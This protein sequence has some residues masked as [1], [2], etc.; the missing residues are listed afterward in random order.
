MSP[1]QFVNSNLI[2]C[3]IKRPLTAFEILILDVQSG[4]KW[5]P[6]VIYQLLLDSECGTSDGLR[7][8]L[9]MNLGINIGRLFL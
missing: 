5:D 4:S 8:C 2:L 7:E 9:E 1:V 6:S 3:K